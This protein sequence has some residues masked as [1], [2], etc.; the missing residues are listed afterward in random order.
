E[1]NDPNNSDYSLTVN[2]PA[3][4]QGIDLSAEGVATDSQGVL[5][6]QGDGFDIGAYEFVP[7]L[8]LSGSAL[9]QTIELTWVID[10]SLANTT[11]WKIEYESASDGNS[12]IVD[13][14]PE[15]TRSYSLSELTNYEAYTI[16]L[17]AMEQNSAIYSDTMTI[18]PTD[19][20]IY[21]PAIFD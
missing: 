21:L 11:T 5:R 4:D 2:S 8:R 19:I 15:P 12:T 1:F 18:M 13:N 10:S 3:V 7:T 6:P 14:L 16:T 20:Q 17:S 9:S